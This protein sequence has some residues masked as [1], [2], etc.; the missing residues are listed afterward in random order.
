M[1]GWIFNLLRELLQDA[2]LYRVILLAIVIILSLFGAKF[3]VFLI[4]KVIKPFVS[5]TKTDLDDKLLA[6]SVSAIYKLSFLAGIFLSV[7]L[8]KDGI[9]NDS[10][11]PP[12][13]LVEISPYLDN[14]VSIAESLL[15]IALIILSFIILFGYINVFLDFYAQ[16]YDSNNKPKFKHKFNLAS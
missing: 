6:V 9:I 3:L 15:F 14:I 5:K 7:E 11:F 12:K 2:L 1:S 16:K 4:K 10:K 8:F 13:L